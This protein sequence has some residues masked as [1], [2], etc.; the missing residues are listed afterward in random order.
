MDALQDIEQYLDESQVDKLEDKVK[1]ILEFILLQ[2][3]E[4]KDLR[5]ALLRNASDTYILQQEMKGMRK[6]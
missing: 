3:E 1:R 6:I 5:T 4:I 2:E